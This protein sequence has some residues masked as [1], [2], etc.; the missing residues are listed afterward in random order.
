[1]CGCSTQLPLA[2]KSSCQ[3]FQEN[4]LTLCPRQLPRLGGNTGADFDKALREYSALY[5][6]CAARHNQLI[7]NIRQREAAWLTK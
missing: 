6:E 2:K 1:M 4:Q 7:N 5:V 3:G